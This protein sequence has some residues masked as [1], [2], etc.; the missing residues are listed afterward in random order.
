VQ[1]KLAAVRA[2]AEA[3]SRGANNGAINSNA[4]TATAPSVVAAAAQAQAH[5]ALGLLQP[6]QQGYAKASQQ[7][8]ES[9]RRLLR[10]CHRTTQ[11]VT[12]VRVASDEAEAAHR[13]AEEQLRQD[14][15]AKLLEEAERSAA[16]NTQVAAGWPPVFDIQVP[17][18]LWGAMEEQRAACEA[19]ISSKDA[20]VAG[21]W[22]FGTGEVVVV[23][24]LVSGVGE[25]SSSSCLIRK[26][27]GQVY[28]PC[29]SLHTELRGALRS[30]DDE[31]VR[32][33]K[34]QAAE[35]DTL[36]VGVAA[37]SG[38]HQSRLQTDQNCQACFLPRISD[39][40]TP[41][42]QNQ[43]YTQAA[44][45]KQVSEMS[46]AYYDELEAI[47]AALLQERGELLSGNQKEVAAMLAARAQAEQE[48]TERYLSSMERYQ[49]Q[50]EE[51]RAHDADE[52]HILKIK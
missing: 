42:S 17:Q 34:R 51:L 38:G 49:Q 25:G 43:N 13:A 6:Q 24:G 28:P 35:I 50:L 30:K 46:Q 48:F 40:L 44:M 27:S 41:E 11:Q 1:E 14:L 45:G 36:L 37:V 3:A 19:I 22:R 7:V 33:L 16:A 12:A 47:E 39:L 23:G 10:M 21:A 29:R 26:H 18:V 15:R 8:A 31:Y 9:Q 52:F 32:L 2:Q 4:A 20:L 5:A